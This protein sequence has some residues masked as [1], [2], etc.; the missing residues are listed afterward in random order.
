M[1]FE[2]TNFGSEDQ[3]EIAEE[4]LPANPTTE[5]D[6]AFIES[7]ESP[8]LANEEDIISD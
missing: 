7:D 6:S 1:D 2:D 4:K 5:Y 8:D 3:F